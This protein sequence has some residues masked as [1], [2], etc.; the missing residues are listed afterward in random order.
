MKVAVTLPQ[1]RHDPGPALAA[2]R[3]AE[4]GGLDGV[5]VFDHLWPLGRPD[6]PA[7]ASFP[8]LGALAAH[9]DRVAVGT[10]VARVG[11]VPNAV[12]AHA[13]VTLARL[14]GERV[15]AGLG[16]GDRLSRAEN[17][18]YGVPFAPVATRLADVV[19]CCDRLKGEGVTAWVGGRSTAIRAVAASRRVPLNVW[20]AGGADVTTAVAGGVEVTWGGEVTD[21]PVRVAGTL[22]GIRAAGA[23]WA[24][25]APRYGEDA[26]AGVAVV[27]HAQRLLLDP[28]AG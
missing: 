28:P 3:A 17:E 6:R 11:L 27:V 4:D 13:F 21:D 1:F 22:R 20:A 2:A 19:E 9:T 26:E 16:T 23:T 8:L 5:F 15:I 14:A 7:L 24:V 25:C 18:A 10:L 12:L